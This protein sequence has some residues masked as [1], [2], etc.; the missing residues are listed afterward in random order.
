MP[1]LHVVVLQTLPVRPKLRKAVLVDIG[2]AVNPKT[3]LAHASPRLQM[4]DHRSKGKLGREDIHR[5]S[6]SGNSPPLLQALKLS[7]SLCLMLAEH[8]V[9]IVG[10]ASI[11]DKERRRR[12][13]GRGRANFLDLGNVVGQW[14]SVHQD[15]MSEAIA[16]IS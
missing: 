2:N 13:R 5:R 6:T 1:Q 15:G 3:P 14:G 11:A 4:Y 10:L 7:S 8:I 9:L 16:P 12:K